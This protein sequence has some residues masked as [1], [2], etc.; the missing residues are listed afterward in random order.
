MSSTSTQPTTSSD[1][2]TP[3]PTG[4]ED[5]SNV[6]KGGSTDF[7]GFLIAFVALVLV[8]VVCGLGSR[9]R[10]VARRRA[11]LTSADMDP[12]AFAPPVHQ[13]EPKYWEPS[14]VPGG[15]EW[16]AIMVGTA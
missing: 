7:F 13:T 15:D 9:R 14:L 6:G 11:I 10:F 5:P 8:F 2:S 16:S 4:F 1:T 3:T 12:W